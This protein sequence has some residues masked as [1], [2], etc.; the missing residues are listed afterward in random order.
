MPYPHC[1]YAQLRISPRKSSKPRPSTERPYY[2][3][4]HRPHRR[5]IRRECYS[6]VPSSH[7]P[8]EV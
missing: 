3:S 5:R 2:S 8:I 7:L 6:S 4:Q 1:Q